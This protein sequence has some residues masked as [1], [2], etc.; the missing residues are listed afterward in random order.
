[1]YKKLISI[2]LVVLTFTFC[3]SAC[4]SK[5]NKEEIKIKINKP[6][7]VALEYVNSILKA[8]FA[9]T[10][11]YLNI[12]EDS[13]F[14]NESDIEFAISDSDFVNILSAGY[15]VYELK[16]GTINDASDTSKSIEVKVCNAEQ[17]EFDYE[18]IYINV[19]RGEDGTWKVIDT[20][21]YYENIA[22]IAPG[23]NTKVYIGDYLLDES[24][25]SNNTS[26][27]YGLEREYKFPI[28]S[29]RGVE[30]T[31]KSDNF[32]YNELIKGT[33]DTQEVAYTI[34]AKIASADECYTYI[35]KAWNGLNELYIAG[36]DID[37]AKVYLSSSAEEDTAQI[38]WDTYE[39]LYESRTIPS[40]RDDNFKLTKCIGTEEKP[41]WIT[42]SK[43]YV[44]FNYELTWYYV[45]ASWQ[46]NMHRE[47]EII[48][49]FTDSTYKLDNVLDIELFSQANNFIM[50]W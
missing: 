23:G 16:V 35:K 46:Q 39:K 40:D 21:M 48:L 2:I 24:Y 29:K 47:S 18:T 28:M 43:V 11:Y 27:L 50:E 42:D 15:Q 5:Q 31:V 1:M 25:I 36:K 6:E 14:I 30:V 37:L 26:G 3:L 7:D 49:E 8:D 19:Y 38:I 9:T 33:Y 22:F 45:L 17:P 12:P 20:D 4:S 10:L 44:P 41:R 34:K 32:E 13:P